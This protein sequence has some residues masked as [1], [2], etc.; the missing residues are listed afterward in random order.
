M[1]MQAVRFVLHGESYKGLAM[2]SP[3]TAR[4]TAHKKNQQQTD[5]AATEQPTSSTIYTP[6][7]SVMCDLCTDVE[8]LYLACSWCAD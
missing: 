6:C 4:I 3:R 2:A 8:T 5:H 7:K 1:Y